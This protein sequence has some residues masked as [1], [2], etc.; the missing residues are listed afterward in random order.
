MVMSTWQSLIDGSRELFAGIAD[1]FEEA[2]NHWNLFEAVKG[3]DE[4]TLVSWT[5]IGWH[6]ERTILPSHVFCYKIMQAAEMK[7]Q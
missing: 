4:N 2:S 6:S 7:E 1:K 5:L 3:K